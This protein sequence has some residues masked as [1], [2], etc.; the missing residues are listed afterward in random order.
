MA[1]T[2]KLVILLLTG[3]MSCGIV[4]AQTNYVVNGSF[5]L[6]VV[7]LGL[8]T[9]VPDDWDVLWNNN[10]IYL[11]RPIPASFPSLPGSGEQRVALLDAAI[12]QDTELV[13]EDNYRYIVEVD[14]Y[15]WVQPAGPDGNIKLYA[16]DGGGS[17]VVAE[18]GDLGTFAPYRGWYTVTIVWDSSGSVHLGKQLGV[19]LEVAT[20]ADYTLDSCRLTKQSYVSVEES[21]DSTIVYEDELMGANTDSYIITL[22]KEPCSPVE[23]QVSPD[24]NGEDIDIGNGAG[25][26]LVLNFPVEDWNTPQTVF[27]SAVNDTLTEGLETAQIVHAANSTDPNYDGI[28]V[29]SVDVSIVDGSVIRLQNA[30]SIELYEEDLNSDMYSLYLGGAPSSNVIVDISTDGQSVTEPNQLTFTPTDYNQPQLIT[31]TVI[32]DEYIERYEHKGII[33]HSASSAD[34]NFNDLERALLVD[35]FDNECGFWH[36]FLPEDLNRDCF[37]NG[38][39]FAKF[40][41]IWLACSKEGYT[42]CYDL[43]AVFPEEQWLVSTP[44]QQDMNSAAIGQIDS[45]MQAAQANGVLIRNGFIVGEWNYAGPADTK[46]EGQSIAKSITSL[47][48]GLAWDEGL[49]PFLDEPVIDY[50]PAFTTSGPYTDKI[51]FRHLVTMTSGMAITNWFQYVDPNNMYPGLEHHYHNDQFTALAEPL[52]YLFE[53]DLKSVLFKKVLNLI[54]ADMD[55]GTCGTIQT[56]TEQSVSVNCGYAYT[57]WSARDL[58][59]IGYLYLNNGKWKQR[60]ILSE[61]YIRETFNAAPYQV[62]EFLTAQSGREEWLSKRRYSLGWWAIEDYPGWFMHGHGEQF[63]LVI[64]EYNVVLV[65]LNSIGVTPYV[66]IEQFYPLV[67]QAVEN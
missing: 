14:I 11:I 10:Q 49:V 45:L 3:L 37:V 34:A 61:S 42:D 7:P 54:N 44:E 50:Y 58:A 4:S 41:S 56:A 62:N 29:P 2:K 1:I 22:L 19:S 16:Y 12:G 28:F 48:L 63:C 27:V 30:G 46:I 24:A 40:A 65:K 15:S 39:D 13:I 60:Q 25:A 55:W 66:E 43:E 18:S 20:G 9:V 6:P 8:N 21:G 36:G 57:Y 67:I 17:T 53:Q 23:V 51:T 59:R 38:L 64:P 26:A 5:E 52:T 32:D 33:L 31:V 35:V 47:A